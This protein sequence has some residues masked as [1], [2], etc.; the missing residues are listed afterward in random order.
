MGSRIG[1]Q[2]NVENPRKGLLSAINCLI[3]VGSSDLAMHCGLLKTCLQKRS[4]LVSA[5]SGVVLYPTAG[6]PVCNACFV[7]LWLHEVTCL[8][9]PSLVGAE[10]VFGL[11][12]LLL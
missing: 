8:N 3:S 6:M 9:K 5:L 10:F 12:M 2:E 4:T 7:P 11:H 1:N